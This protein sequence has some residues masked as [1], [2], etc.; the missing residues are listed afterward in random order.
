MLQPDEVVRTWRSRTCCP[1]R[2][3]PGPG[4]WQAL[5]ASGAAE[6]QAT[7][8]LRSADRQRPV[9]RCSPRRTSGRRE[10]QAAWSVASR[11]ETPAWARKAPKP[12]QVFRSPCHGSSMAIITL[13]GAA[14][15]SGHA[16]PVVS[17]PGEAVAEEA[18]RVP[19]RPGG[20]V[21]GTLI[22]KGIFGVAGRGGVE[23][24]G[25][26]GEQEDVDDLPDVPDAHAPGGGTPAGGSISCIHSGTAGIAA[27]CGD[28]GDGVELRERRHR[29]LGG[30]GPAQ[31]HLPPREALRGELVE[32]RG[33]GRRAAARAAGP[34]RRSAGSPCCAVVEERRRGAD[35][36]EG[37]A[38]DDVLVRSCP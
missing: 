18:D 33:Q 24:S 28:G 21:A 7:G 20:R 38:G 3:G 25:R 17:G 13:S 2:S 19:V 23:G 6:V 14:R 34:A 5:S 9:E 15:P 16:E 36:G 11:P 35:Q 22:T 29:G 26:T 8:L 10:A 4:R 31:G 37:R 1:G 12:V 30:E 27:A 32:E